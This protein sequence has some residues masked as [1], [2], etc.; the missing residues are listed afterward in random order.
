MLEYIPKKG[1]KDMV[2]DFKMFIHDIKKLIKNLKKE[3]IDLWN[4]EESDKIEERQNHIIIVFRYL[5]GNYYLDFNKTYSKK[6]IIYKL[7]KIDENIVNECINLLYKKNLITNKNKFKIDL[8]CALFME[9][10]ISR[11]TTSKLNLFNVL[12][13]F[14][15]LILAIATLFNNKLTNLFAISFIITAL[16]YMFKILSDG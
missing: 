13:I 11:N 16:L 12:S 4:N 10:L 5:I 14:A 3:K 7:K 1:V 8:E 2:D 9:E 6:E 15:T